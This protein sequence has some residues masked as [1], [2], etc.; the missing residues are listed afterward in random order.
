[1]RPIYQSYPVYHPD[2]EPSGY[3]R[4]VWDSSK[5]RTREDW[6]NA[7]EFVFDAPILY[8]GIGVRPSAGEDLHVRDRSWNERVRPPLTREGV[9][10][11]HRYVIRKR[12]KIELGVLAC[13]MCHTRVLPDGSILNGVPHGPAGHQS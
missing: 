9:L 2:W 5:L 8:G 11:F 7:G 10:P 13:A 4:E 3:A 12:D 6:V 1:M